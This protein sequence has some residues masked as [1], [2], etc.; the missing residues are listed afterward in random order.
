M[1]QSGTVNIETQTEDGEII[2][3]CHINEKSIALDHS[4]S[5]RI[6]F[7]RNRKLFDKINKKTKI[8]RGRVIRQSVT[9]AKSYVNRLMVKVDNA[10]EH[11]D[12]EIATLIFDGQH[13]KR[14][15]RRKFGTRYETDV[16]PDA[17]S[18]G[19]KKSVFNPNN[20][21][22]SD[23]H[24]SKFISAVQELILFQDQGI[25]TILI[26]DNV[27]K[28]SSLHEVSYS[29]ELSVD[30]SFG[31]YIEFLYDRI[32]KTIKF[33]TIYYNTMVNGNY[34]NHKSKKYKKSY[35]DQILSNLG[36]EYTNDLL[37]DVSS[38]NIKTSDFGLAAS[39]YYNGALLLADRSPMDYNMI[40][41]HLLP[42]NNNTP[43]TIGSMLKSFEDL[44]AKIG[45]IYDLVKKKKPRVYKKPAT[46]FTT[47]HFP[48]KIYF[49]SAK[50]K[51]ENDQLGYNIFSNKQKGLNVFSRA[52]Y[53]RRVTSE[54]ERYYHSFNPGAELQILRPQERSDF[55]NTRNALAFLTPTSMIMGKDA[56][57][58]TRGILGIDPNKIKEFR[59]LKSIK[60][61]KANQ[62][63]YAK[64]TSLGKAPGATLSK[65]N[66]FVGPAVTSVL[67]SGTTTDVEDN[68]INAE[69]YLGSTSFFVTDSPTIIRKNIQKLFKDESSRVLSI[70]SDI[71]PHKF[72]KKKGAVRSIKEIN[73]G[74]K[75][76]RL[77]QAVIA[78]KI[79]LVNIPPQIK[80]MCINSFIKP[81]SINDPLKNLEASQIIQ[82]TQ[83]NV[84]IVQVLVGFNKNL[85][86]FLDVRMPIIQQMGSSDIPTGRP[87]LAKAYDY[88]IPDL[89][90]IKDK[91]STTIYNNLLYIKD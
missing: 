91:L 22:R 86:G 5:A 53:Q 61:R 4:P 2:S 17:L 9:R 39:N 59:I 34:Y 11:T 89:G 63:T 48:K 19:N 40:I 29:V 43:T 15:E 23:F 68:F 74:N 3:I 73:I 79:D 66:I 18:E 80:A 36:I 56:I 69:E 35:V 57:D 76:S 81:G 47:H 87:L 90:M 27:G 62:N 26:R 44:Q 37:L 51:I 32:D 25:R 38:N 65:F 16:D 64:R 46:S 33:L 84:Y 14:M 6:L 49:A 30:S 82:E 67:R 42:I 31:E 12:K 60:S 10:F 72:L 54:K 78:E 58:T 7:K 75:N 1:P 20:I 45:N 8:V 13:L 24:N 55:L 71:I 77:R 50:F 52:K 83:Q 85:D 28:D 70:V 21:T 41:N 88:E